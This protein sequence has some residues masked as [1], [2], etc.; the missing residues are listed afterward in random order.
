VSPWKPNKEMVEWVWNYFASRQAKTPFKQY[1]TFIPPL[2]LQH[3][4]HSR[5]IIGVEKRANQI[6]LLI[7]DPS[8]FGPALLNDLR[9]KKLR[10]VKKGLDTFV[11]E[12]YQIV[13]IEKNLMTHEELQDAKIFTS[14]RIC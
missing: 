2:Y 9:N 11:R 3:E 13:C 10:K 4:G 14:L 6:N 8:H 12:K 7:F 1:E 5:T